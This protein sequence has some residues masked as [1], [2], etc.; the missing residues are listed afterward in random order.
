MEG[1]ATASPAHE[2]NPGTA[3]T[4]EARRLGSRAFRAERSRFL[5]EGPQAVREALRGAAAATDAERP[6]VVVRRLWW[7]RRFSDRNP[8]FVDLAT[9]AGIQGVELSDVDLAKLGETATPQGVVAVCDFLP[10]DLDDVLARSPRM[11][12][13]LAQVR[14][15]GNAGT[16]IRCA[17]AAGADAVVLSAGSVDAYNPKA[18]RA[19]VG[20]H[21]HLPVGQDL[22]LAPT[23]AAIRAAGLTIL[24]ADGGVAG[25]V[26]LDAAGDS[27]L[28]ARPVAWLLGNEAWGLPP[29]DL[30]LA[31]EVVAVPLHGRAESL[32]LATAAAV[33]LYAT[34]RAQRR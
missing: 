6:P 23:L 21:F 14:D 9:T 22:P 29:A 5:V 12:V 16:V 26:D 11:L 32:N 2:E 33:C 10:F 7:T 17:D 30:A 8:D 24:A 4:R 34:A 19:A 3:G 27:G 25:A 15:P 31:D 18:V 1:P 20:S 13:V 28:L